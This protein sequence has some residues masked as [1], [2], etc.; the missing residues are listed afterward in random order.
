[1]NKTQAALLVL[2]SAIW[3]GSF[4]FMR[5]LSP[6]YGPVYTSSLR[7]LSA[8]FFLYS[9]YLIKHIKVEWK[10]N[11]KWFLIIG[12]LNSAI[13]FT[14]Y[15]FAALY[16]PAN[17]SVILNSTSPMFGLL[18]GVLIIHE[19]ITGKKI[20][21]LVLGTLGVII[22]TSVTFDEIDIYVIL[23]IG[24][25]VLAASLYGLSGALIKKYASNIPSNQ[26]VLGSM[27]LGGLVLLPFGLLSPITGTITIISILMMITFG[28]IGTAVTYLIYFALIR[29][30]G[31]VKALMTTYVMPVFGIVWS[32]LFLRE[33]LRLE[34]ILGLIII[35]SGIYLIT[36]KRKVLS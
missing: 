12:L 30:L 13:P 35:L 29:D 9:Y 11:I 6:I 3:G 15:A 20:M 28:V 24:A 10:S 14:L 5:V 8:S 32:I 22:I 4:I 27:F 23:S 18:F 31:P 7:L 17:L 1:M 36:S 25:C 34:S 2:I 19:K 33:T 26:L 21:G 16:L